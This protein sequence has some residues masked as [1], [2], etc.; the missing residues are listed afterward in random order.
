MKAVLARN[1][2]LNGENGE[3]LGQ[4]VLTNDGMFASVTAYGNLACSWAMMEST[5]FRVFLIGLHNG[6]FVT[7]LYTGMAYI[8]SGEEC[9]KVCQKYA[10]KILPALQKV[11]KEELEKGVGWTDSH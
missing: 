5:D 11:L 10:N 7:K 6:Y 2:T 9:E 8:L 4:V 3:W 1:Y